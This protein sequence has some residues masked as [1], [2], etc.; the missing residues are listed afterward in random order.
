MS[1]PKIDF[2]VEKLPRGQE[3]YYYYY[4]YFDMGSRASVRKSM[5]RKPK[6]LWNIGELQKCGS[7]VNNR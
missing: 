5:D 1:A 7:L 2:L 4:Y 3:T 6:E